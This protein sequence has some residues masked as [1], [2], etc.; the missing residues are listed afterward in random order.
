MV[1]E[2]A[3]KEWFKDWFDRDY[4]AIYERRDAGEAERAVAM[5]LEAAPCLG[6]GPVL[7]L[8]C[9]SGRHLAVL[10]RT[11]PRA[12]GLDLSLDLLGMAPGDLKPWLLR[13]DMRALPVKAGTLSGLCMWFTPF[14]YFSDEQNRALLAAVAALLRP[15][16]VAV[17]DYFNA[18][19][20]RAHL[21][22]EDETTH[23][24]L[25]VV[26]R[27]ALEGSRVVKRMDLIR[28]DTGTIRHATESVRLYE[29][30]ELRALASSCGLEAYRES[31]GYSGR[32][33]A[34]G[35]PRW[36]GFLRRM[37]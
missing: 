8:A 31:G 29:P 4:A 20:V 37:V 19:H 15:G 17:L 9:G 28:L 33:F 7:D 14:G 32:P 22:R 36:I 23:Q 21:V 5:A 30:E 6:E 12:F 18:S 11:N 16:G 2:A 25:R 26:S 24:G 35:S 13:A 3:V 10:R 34:P 1:P 27:R